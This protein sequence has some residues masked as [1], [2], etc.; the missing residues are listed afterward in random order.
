MIFKKSLIPVAILAVMIFLSLFLLNNQPSE[1]ATTQVKAIP[2]GGAC[3]TPKVCDPVMNQCVCQVCE[4]PGSC[5]ASGACNCGGCSNKPG[6]GAGYVCS[7]AT[8]IGHCVKGFA[9]AL[10]W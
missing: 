1:A 5:G 9:P 3:P 7:V 8:G 2:C 4:N 10:T 6:Y